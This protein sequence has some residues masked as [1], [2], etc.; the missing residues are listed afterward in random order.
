MH[1]LF[2]VR[3]SSTDRH[4]D[5]RSGGRKEGDRLRGEDTGEAGQVGRGDGRRQARA[6]PV[7]RDRRRGGGSAEGEE[8]GR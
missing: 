8:A 1:S 4:G 3:E 2:H 6:E 7:R 5:P